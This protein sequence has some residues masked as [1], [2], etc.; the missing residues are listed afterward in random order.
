MART[1]PIILTQAD[2]A[3]YVAQEADFAFEM[4]A[5]HAIRDAGFDAEHAAAYKDPVTGRIRAYDIRARWSSPTEAYRFAVECKNLRPHAPLLVHATP[6]LESEAY[7]TVIARYRVGNV[8]S[9]THRLA[10]VYQRGVP[11]GRQTDQ[12]MKDDKGDFKS[13]DSTTYEKWSQ[14]VSSCADLVREAVNAAYQDPQVCAIVPILVVPDGVLWQVDYDEQG[15]ISTAVRQIDRTTL[16]LR[17]HWSAEVMFGP[18]HYDI[19]HVEIVT[20]SSLVARMK[21]LWGPNGLCAGSEQLL[22]RLVS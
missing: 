19:S 2:L 21:Y 13:N 8:F 5:L 7:H 6:R 12:P 17:Q 14:A 16:I 15:N 22:K 9:D 4:A 11:V 18:L 1:A 10:G 20:L 3:Q